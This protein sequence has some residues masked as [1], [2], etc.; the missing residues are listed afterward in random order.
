MKK[1]FD[2]NFQ[3]SWILA[4]RFVYE[5]V[6]KT[7]N[8]WMRKPHIVFLSR[9]TQTHN[10]LLLWHIIMNDISLFIV[11]NNSNITLKNKQI[12]VMSKS[13]WCEL[14]GQFNRING[15][16]NFPY[17]YT[18]HYELFI[19]GVSIMSTT[20]IFN[21]IKCPE[22]SLKFIHLRDS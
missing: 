21:E 17:F 6:H 20:C 19:S 5:W 1:W 8:F 12:N 18:S 14:F 7:M 13:C 11:T 4:K 22:I 10:S 2:I 9:I 15:E 3:L 16:K